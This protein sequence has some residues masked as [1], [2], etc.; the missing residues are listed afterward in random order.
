MKAQHFFMEVLVLAALAIMTGLA[1]CGVAN[2]DTLATLAGFENALRAKEGGARIDDPVDIAYS[3]S[4]RA[5]DLYVILSK[6]SK[7][8]N[9]DLSKSSV[10]GF[11][12]AFPSGSAMIVSLILPDNLASIENSAFYQWDRLTHVTMPKSVRI[13]GAEAF[14]GCRGLTGVTIPSGVVSIGRNAFSGCSELTRVTIPSSVTGIEDDAFSPC[15]ALTRVTFAG[16]D[17]WVAGDG[18]F[19]S[20]VRLRSAAGGSGTGTYKPKAGIYQRNNGDW[21]RN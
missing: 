4:G 14:R 17:T 12:D 8:V 20:G 1:G 19:P 16:N 18:V 13:I 15:V 7:F 21:W 11:E 6:V 2:P 10:T 9:L 3:G 5:Y